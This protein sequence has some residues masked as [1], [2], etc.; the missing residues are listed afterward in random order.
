[1]ARV[2]HLILSAVTLALAVAV[3]VQAP[4][5]NGPAEWEW[6]WRPPG[7]P[8]LAWGPALL[9]AA[10]AAALVAMAAG[11]GAGRLFLPA[12]GLAGALL[13]FALIA[14]QPGG[15][16]RVLG[17]LVSRN[18]FG[19]VWDAALAPET[20]A[21]LADYP[22]ASVGLNQHSRTHPPGPLLLVRA[23]DRLDRL[24]GPGGATAGNRTEGWTGAA[25]AAIDREIGR[26]RDRRRPLPERPPVPEAVLALAILLPLAGAAAVWPLASLARSWELPPAAVSFA[27]ALWLLLPART[28]FTP[29]LDQALPLLLTGAAALAAGKGWPRAALA[30]VVLFAA[31]FLTWGCLAAVPFLLLIAAAANPGGGG[32]GRALRLG[33]WR[34]GIAAPAVAGTAFAAP[35]VLLYATTAFNP[36]AA[37]SSALTLHRQIAVDTRSYSLWLAW[38]PY[39]VALLAGPIVVGLAW[40]TMVAP[41][42]WREGSRGAFFLPLLGFWGLLILLW[43]S[44]SV[45]GE[46]G[47]IWLMWMPF[48]CVYAAA[49][50]GPMPGEEG[51]GRGRRAVALAA[52]ALL[53]F[54]LAASMSFV[55]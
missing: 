7:P 13:T 3:F 14:A 37:L 26:A 4:W 29:S 12:A 5:A 24:G 6:T 28:L 21:L 8:G 11:R 39:D 22:A 43:I 49:A 40:M 46:I 17:S 51:R 33:P 30:G 54:A 20:A 35:W 55:S 52:Q 9:A 42:T 18:S 32:K 25:R 34:L 38:N 16:E 31:C 19:Y 53:L 36:L 41:K 47:R 10:A 27:A 45:R 15:L 44:G 2:L 48:A 1:M 50:V 23:L